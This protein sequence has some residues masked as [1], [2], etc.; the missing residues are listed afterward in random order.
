[1]GAR[2]SRYPLGLAAVTAARLENR[3]RPALE[4]IVARSR[5]R[6]RLIG[7]R[8]AYVGT[9]EHGCNPNTIEALERRGYVKTTFG[10]YG[11]PYKRIVCIPTGAGI[12]EVE[13]VEALRG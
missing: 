3:L 5:T 10:K 12:L 1:V 7:R 4:V 8:L 6:G 2:A 13:G 11:A 9:R